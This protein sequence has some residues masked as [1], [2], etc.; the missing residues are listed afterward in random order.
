MQ[1]CYTVLQFISLHPHIVSIFVFLGN[2]EYMMQNTY[3]HAHTQ[4]M[5]TLGLHM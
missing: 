3:T 2:T 4:P 5:N 1:D